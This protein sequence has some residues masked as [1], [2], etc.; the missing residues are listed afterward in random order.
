MVCMFVDLRISVGNSRLCNS[1]GGVV[2]GSIYEIETEECS[3]N[4]KC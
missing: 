1:V 2:L 4:A 3:S